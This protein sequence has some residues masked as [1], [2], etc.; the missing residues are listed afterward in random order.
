MGVQQFPVPES[1]IPKGA[2]GARPAAPTIGTVFYNGTTTILEIWDGDSWVPC[3]AVAAQPTISVADVGTG[4]AYTGAQATVTFTPGTIGGNAIGYTA[5]A[6]TGGYSAT[7]TGTTATITVGNPGSWT[8]SGTSY[9]GYGTS[10]ASPS[11]TITLT[12]NPEAASSVVP[13]ISGTDITFTWTL[14]ATGGKNL[15]AQSIVP[16]LNGTTEQTVT[17]VSTTATTGTVTG[18][19]A[20]S[21]YTFKIRKTNANGTTDSVATSAVTVPIT[22]NYLVVAG[23][24]GGGSSGGN[25][26]ETGGGGG[27]G[28]MV[29]GTTGLAFATTTTVTVGAGG[30]NRAA[31]SNSQ[32]GSISASVGG[33]KGERAFNAGGNG[34]SGG[35]GGS[36]SFAGG[37]GTSG[38]GNAGGTGVSNLGGGGGGKGGAASGATGGAG[39][40]SSITGSSVTYATGGT[41]GGTQANAGANT[42]NG[43]SGA[44][45]TNFP[46]IDGW[47]GGS[48]VVVI[49]YPDTIAAATSTTGSPTVTT[50]GGNRIYKWT[51]S[52]SITL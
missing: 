8:I 44:I 29:T 10:P 35:G 43:G 6:S 34:G 13:T 5:S 46:T 9:N 49:S 25:N 26:A 45:G 16:F 24:G 33:G 17:T 32:F 23:G 36:P 51:G 3:S 20:G 14:G 52:G 38:Q 37:T 12:T 22:I 7:T 1:G 21:S 41:G 28:G 18:L 19:T 11:T 31:G 40:A 42:G 2:T 48:G 4:V 39:S 27:A 50:S 15:S 47:T 30:G